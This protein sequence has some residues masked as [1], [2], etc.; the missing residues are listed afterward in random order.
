[1][2]MVMV[3]VMPSVARELPMTA[4]PTI[5]VT[6]TREG[7]TIDVTG[8]GVLT[9]ELYRDD[10]Y[11]APSGVNPETSELI[12]SAQAEG[13][14]HYVIVRPYDVSES[15]QCIV[16]ATAQ[17]ANMLPSYE[18]TESFLMKGIFLLPAPIISFQEDEEGLF[19]DVVGE[20]HLTVTVGV[21]VHNDSGDWGEEEYVNVDVSQLP[22]YVPRTNEEQRIFV[23]ARCD[24]YGSLD[25][26]PNGATETYVLSASQAPSDPVVTPAPYI[27]VEEEADCVIIHADP[28]YD[29]DDPYA[30]IVVYLYIDG[31]EVDNPCVVL[32]TDEVQDLGVSAYAVNMSNQSA[33]PSEWVVYVCIVNPLTPVLEYT[34]AP[35]FRYYTNENDNCCLIIEEMEPSTIYYRQG[36]HNDVSQEFEYGEW[37]EYEEEFVFTVPG[38]YRIEAYAV[39]DGKYPSNEIAFECLITKPS[40]SYIYDFEEGGIYYKITGD[41]KVNVCAETTDY[42]TYSGYVTIP[43]TVTHDGV[44]YM[45][46]GIMEDAF[47]DC[48][49]LTG[50]TI[51]AYVTAI[52]DRA[53]MGCTSLTSVTLGDYVITLGSEAFSCCSSL[54]S[55]VLGSGLASIGTKAFEGC[56]ALTSVTCKSATPPV[57]AGSDCFDCYGVATLHVHPAVLDIYQATNY[58]NQFASIVGEDKVAPVTGDTNGDGVL[59]ISDVTTL[60]NWLLNE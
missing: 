28:T 27:W 13:S 33:D 42:N 35:V 59:G 25:V 20:G 51:G 31:Q 2:I 43:A 29:P 26:W 41:G 50:V 57:M 19:I 22:Y 3:A 16:V 30:D 55:V 34:A 8:E 36:V 39:A 6:E 58:W 4:T 18:A 12:E 56:S 44:T 37:M 54:A 1:M 7:Y 60:I 45:V 49:G 11:S 24:G 17:G 10:P 48:S 32:R 53:F 46:S 9:V 23:E 15:F 38:K 47:R 5:L 21:S 52:G 14:Y 40:P